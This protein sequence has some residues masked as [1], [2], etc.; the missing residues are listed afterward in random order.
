MRFCFAFITEVYVDLGIANPYAH[1]TLASFTDPNNPRKDVPKLNGKGMEAR[2][3]VIPVYKLWKEHA[4]AYVDFSCVK[5]LLEAQCKIQLILKSHD[6]LMFLPLDAVSDLRKHIN[7]FLQT[8]QKLALAADADP[9]KDLLWNCPTKF[10]QMWH[11]G[12][13][14]LYLHP[15]TGSCLLDED[16]VGKMK[17]I[18]RACSEGTPAHNVPIGTMEKY[19]WALHFL[20]NG[21]P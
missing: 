4:K 8:Y 10:H 15:K 14:S 11:F 16:F 3:L 21:T 13:K 9:R 20:I 5:D 19:T 12:H 6:H 2:D 17:L 18:V 7:V 1:L